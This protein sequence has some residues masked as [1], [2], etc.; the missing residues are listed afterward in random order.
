MPQAE[1]LAAAN[2]RVSNILSKS[3]APK[4]PLEQS[5]LVEPAEQALAQAVQVK[6]QQ[7]Q[8]L[9]DERDY[10]PA[11]E[12]SADLQAPVDAFFEQVMVMT[13]DAA[14]QTNRL[15]ELLQLRA[16]SLQVVDVRLRELC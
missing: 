7:V 13:D 2:K 16:L 3:G 10:T 11:L 15:A 1:S 9:F 14:L 6:A 8:P 12:S 5:L 4:A